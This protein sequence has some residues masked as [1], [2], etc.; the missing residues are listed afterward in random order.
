MH[1]VFCSDKRLLV[2][3]GDDV[4][5]HDDT[6]FLDA[7]MVLLAKFDAASPELPIGNKGCPRRGI[8]H[9]IPNNEVADAESGIGPACNTDVNHF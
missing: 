3:I 5:D 7:K 6:T 2:R 9:H 4:F 1:A 8:D